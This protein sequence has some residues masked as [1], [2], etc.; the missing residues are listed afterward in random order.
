MGSEVWPWV[1]KDPVLGWTNAAG[2]QSNSFRVNSYGFR[3]EEFSREKPEGVTRIVCIGDSGTFGIWFGERSSRHWDNYP[4]ELR[5]ILREEGDDSVEVINAGVVGA[6]SSHSLRQLL[7]RVLV[8]Q[9]D[10][11]TVRIRV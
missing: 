7:T 3:G 1:V 5:R 8:L 9:P 11:L 2:Y 6:T 4:G 10:I